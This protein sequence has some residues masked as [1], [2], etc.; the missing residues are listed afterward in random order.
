MEKDLK[1]AKNIFQKLFNQPARNVQLGHGSF[2]TMGFGKD[3]KTK[4]IIHKKREIDIRPEWFFWAYMCFWELEK[5][6]ELLAT[7][8]DDKDN[9]KNALKFLEGKKLI[10]V[11]ILED[12]YEIQLEFEGELLLSLYTDDSEDDNVQW[13][14][15]T[16]D[17]MVLEATANQKL[18]YTKESE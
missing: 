5:P 9:M 17:E 6:N 3:L 12:S 10:N 8:E 14:L 18:I 11:E 7:S 1:F 4:V 16:P 13:M 15:F 2:I